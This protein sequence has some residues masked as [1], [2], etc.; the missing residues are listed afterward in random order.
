MTHKKVMTILVYPD[1]MAVDSLSLAPFTVIHKI[2][3]V[4]EANLKLQESTLAKNINK[5]NIFSCPDNIY[6]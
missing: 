4:S 3:A 1:I 5:L 2:G 6:I